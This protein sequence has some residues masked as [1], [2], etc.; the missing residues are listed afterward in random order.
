MKLELKE[1]PVKAIT[2]KNL[3]I[4]NSFRFSMIIIVLLIF[5]LGYRFILEKKYE[6]IQNKIIKTQE[7]QQKQ[8][9]L[10]IRF[11]ELDSILTKY[12]ELDNGFADKINLILPIQ[13]IKEELFSQFEYL[14]ESNGFMLKNLSISG[15]TPPNQ[16]QNISR[17]GNKSPK[18]PQVN[19]LGKVH[20]TLNIV[21]IDYEGM[22]KII[23]IIENNMR[24]MDINN[25]N[26]SPD[27]NSLA[28][29]IT[30]YYQK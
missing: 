14:I 7:K 22:K 19:S 5:F 8:A 23:N 17:H 1:K 2:T 29:G 9:E 10:N 30:T 11:Q 13:E 4:F 20:I 15:F 26:F 6:H 24:I 18:I 21:G 3:I 16:N 12:K 25:L 27:S 28:L